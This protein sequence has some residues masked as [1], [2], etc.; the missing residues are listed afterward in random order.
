MTDVVDVCW[1][2]R[3]MLETR[4]KTST[5][6]LSMVR[7]ST[8]C[9]LCWFVQCLL[10]NFVHQ[11]KVICVLEIC[12]EMD[13]PGEWESQWKEV[14]CR[15]VTGRAY[16]AS[17]RTPITPPWPRISTL[18]PSGV[19]PK[20]QNCCKGFRFTEKVEKRWDVQYLA[21]RS[22]WCCRSTSGSTVSPV[23]VI[24]HYLHSFLPCHIPQIQIPLYC[25]SP[26]Y[27]LT[28]PLS[29]E[30]SRSPVHHLIC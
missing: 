20:N 23:Q 12:M 2:E 15:C 25:W 8:H 18:R 16:S 3:C 11:R 14:W 1:Q 6:V 27:P 9:R 21:L 10:L 29:F 19:P 26:W 4:F 17:C 7:H 24:P 28:F 22:S 13:Y 5:A 30:V